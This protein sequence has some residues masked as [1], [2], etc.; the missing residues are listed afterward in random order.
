MSIQY[1]ILEI[2]RMEIDR[3][4]N[5]ASVVYGELPEA[6]NGLALIPMGGETIEPN[7]LDGGSYT[8]KLGLNGSHT[9]QETVLDTLYKIHETLD[10]EPSLTI[11]NWTIT[12]IAMLS[13]PKFEKHEEGFWTYSSVLTIDYMKD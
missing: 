12:S 8:L 10:Q 7:L 2:L 3:F 4:S 13:A 9:D 5:Y 1:Q 11:A 6:A